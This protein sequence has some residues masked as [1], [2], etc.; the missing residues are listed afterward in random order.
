[1]PAFDFETLWD[2]HGR[3]ALAV[4]NIGG[5]G[6]A[7]AAP[8]DG[9]DA[10]PMWVADMNFATAPSVTAALKARIEHPLYG[11]FMPSDAYYGAVI[12]W[13]AVR[14]GVQGLEPKHIGY[15][16]GVLGCVASALAAFT[17]PGDAVLLHSPTY[18]GFSHTLH[19]TAR[20][21]ELSPL[22]RDET[23]VWRMDFADMDC[24][25]RENHIRL[26]IFCSPHNPCGRVWERWELE[27][28]A[29]VFRANDCIVVSDE[30][31]SDILPG[32]AKHI[33]L[34][35]VSEDM[36]KRTIAVYAPSKTFNLAGL[37]G[38]YHIVYSDHLRHEL[39]SVSGATHYN[40]MNVLSMHALIGA[41][42][43]EGQAWTDKLCSVLAEN[44][45]TFCDA[46]DAVCPEAVYMRPKGTY[47]LFVNVRD[48]CECRGLTQRDVLCAGW[49]VGLCWQDGTDFNDPWAIRIN[50]ASPLSVIQK[51]AERLPLVFS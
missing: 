21:A 18:V 33:P 7:P 34:Q 45:R 14:N 48:Y 24:R 23:G 12:R 10:I 40:G 41:Y 13:Q 51:A 9:Y 32:A 28:A 6:F 47:M 30:I 16:N 31:W 50:L 26:V 39:R 15:E 43:D 27:R 37:V 42:S 2:R 4:D 29:E 19:D 3:D 46:L 20:R 22:V 8:E 5:P 38:S 25:I 36:K 11:Y 49:R 35:S 17:K 1:M 44:I